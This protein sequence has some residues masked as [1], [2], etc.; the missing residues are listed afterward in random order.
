MRAFRLLMAIA[1][2]LVGASCGSL[3]H[4]QSARR[5]V[6]IP[7]DDLTTSKF[8]LLDRREVQWE[9]GLTK[10]QMTALGKAFNTPFT[11]I[12]GLGEV[13]S[14]Y[15]ALSEDEKRR[16]KSQYVEE[17]NTVSLKWLESQLT[18]ILS[19]KQ[20]G[21][22]DALLLQMKGPRAIII[23]P[24]MIGE[25]GLTPDQTVK[26][27]NI[28]GQY[29]E[30]LSPFSHRYGHNMLQYSRSSQTMEESE[31]EQDAIVV[32]ITEILKARDESI[33]SELTK[34]QCDE[35]R[36]MQGRLLPVSWPETAGFYVPFDNYRKASNK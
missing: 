27:Q 19:D 2:F 33:L 18:D 20:K 16:Q 21:R 26:I 1:L 3:P 13:H 10:G 22:L 4:T 15:Q 25:L 7:E 30:E 36:R 29:S 12:P 6:E 11:E 24:G 23:V 35:W 28:V 5:Y 34:A 32:I 17:R 14:R 8:Y 9:L 31:K